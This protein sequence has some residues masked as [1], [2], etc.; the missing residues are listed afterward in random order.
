MGNE[1]PNNKIE[2]DLRSTRIIW[3]I[4]SFC[5]PIYLSYIY[6]NSVLHGNAKLFFSGFSNIPW[7]DP[8]VMILLGLAIFECLF[9]IF[10]FRFI[11]KIIKLKKIGFARL[12]RVRILLTLAILDSVAIYGL[13]IGV[14]HGSRMAS[15][16]LCLLLVPVIG[17]IVMAPNEKEFRDAELSR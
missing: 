10:L 13:V 6:I 11:P 16:S 12:Y 8:F 7:S 2:K 14:T 4:L 15:M 3:T 1:N 5:F 17:G 9:C